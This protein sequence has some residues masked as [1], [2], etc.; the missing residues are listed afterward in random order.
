MSNIPTT[1]PADELVVG[2]PELSVV[3]CSINPDNARRTQENIM[4]TSGVN[5]EFIIVDNRTR[6]WP[7]ARAYNFG[8]SQATAQNLFFAHEDILFEKE[9]WGKDIVAK[10]AEPQTG[11]IG[12]IGSQIRTGA[13]APWS[14]DHDHSIGHIYYYQ[15]GM[16]EILHQGQI[17]D[18]LF[19]PVLVVDG[20]GMF[21]KK[22]V[23][24]EF[25]FDEQILTGF[26]CYDIDFCLT[27][28][29]RYHNYVYFGGDINHL[30]NGKMDS[31]WAEATKLL[32]D[33][34]WSVMTPMKADGVGEV[35]FQKL[36]ADQDYDF[37]WRLIRQPQVYSTKF[38]KGF[39]KKFVKNASHDIYYQ[40]HLFVILWQYLIK[41]IM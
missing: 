7:I 20:L 16:K 11:V 38:V 1:P 8:A 25:P 37:L 39:V 2:R 13:Y 14:E 21:V 31:R 23:W 19:R 24:K 17:S 34:K 12:F 6:K 27:I 15:D 41:R 3:I 28:A 40:R 35:N 22:A 30:S 33:K 18:V 32:T 5:C 36:K 9:D 10:L 4:A 26:H 29:S